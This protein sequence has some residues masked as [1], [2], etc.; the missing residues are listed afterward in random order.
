MTEEIFSEEVRCYV[1]ESG[2]YLF[3]ANGPAPVEGISVF[4]PPENGDQT[5]LFSET[6]PFWSVSP[7]QLRRVE[8]EWRESELIVISAQLDALE[9]AEAGEAPTDL[10]VGT[11][12]QWLK[13]RGL[14]RTW[15]EGNG[16][17]PGITKR[18]RRPA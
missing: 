8:E 13:Y 6:A 12:P 15:T 11:R 17:Y 16:D 18:P 1:D 10:L 5:W 9:E 2:R 3:S 4:P 14:V 7:S